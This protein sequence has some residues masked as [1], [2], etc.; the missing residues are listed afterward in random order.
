M[1]LRFGKDG[2][3]HRTSELPSVLPRKSG[4][5]VY[6]QNR[7]SGNRSIDSLGVAGYYVKN[8]C[9]SDSFSP[10]EGSDPQRTP[11]SRSSSH[12]AFLFLSFFHLSIHRQS[13]SIS[14]PVRSS[15]NPST[16]DLFAR[17]FLLFLPSSPHPL[18]LLTSSSSSSSSRY[19][20]TV[21]TLSFVFPILFIP[22][23]ILSLTLLDFSST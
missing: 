19:R 6:R 10:R 13:S 20:D 5:L 14:S 1:K 2:I 3:R 23:D 12:P 8:S 9:S 17:S 18:I 11:L 16:R 22:P 4:E 15:S 7:A 21:S